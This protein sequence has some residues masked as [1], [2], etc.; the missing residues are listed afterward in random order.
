MPLLDH[1]HPPVS[2]LRH[3]ESFHGRWAHALAD[4]LNRN[5]PAGYFSE[6]QVSIGGLV[7]VDVATQDSRAMG[8]PSANGG[9]ATATLPVSAPPTIA[10][11]MPL[12]FP[13][14]FEVRLFETS[15]GPTLVGAIELVSPRN[16]DRPEARRAFIAKSLNYLTQGI[17][18]V[19]VDVVTERTSNLHDEL[20]RWIGLGEPFLFPPD[21]RLYAVAYRPRRT[22]E[23]G[24]HA[25][26]IK[27]ALRV[28]QSLPILPLALRGGPE[29]QLDLDAA[30]N[31]ARERSRM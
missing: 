2:A 26:L 31:E 9:T 8:T 3:W 15:S 20:V 14:E 28:G 7:E 29:L 30:Y 17:G 11:A 19:V 10:L 22:P 21:T 5:L 16:K 23:A 4:A 1:F 25:E 13:D 12:V 24:D 18:L 6:A 27:A